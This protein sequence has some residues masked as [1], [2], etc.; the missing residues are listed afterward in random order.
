MRVGRRWAGE[1]GHICHAWASKSHP[2]VG[3]Q[4]Q[5]IHK[6]GVARRDGTPLFGK[7][8]PAGLSHQV[9]VSWSGRGPDWSRLRS[10]P[11]LRPS[12]LAPLPGASS[13]DRAW[14]TPGLGSARHGSLASSRM[15]RTLDGQS[16]ATQGPLHCCLSPS[17]PR[18]KSGRVWKKGWEGEGVGVTFDPCTTLACKEIP[19]TFCNC[20]S[21][22]T[23]VSRGRPRI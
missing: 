10:I 21:T 8:F 18:N 6:R 1:E 2:P 11:P 23:I 22:H 15:E 19:P 5:Q 13:L 3:S 9:P 12:P 16:G 4:R 17:G 20:R 7:H 14:P